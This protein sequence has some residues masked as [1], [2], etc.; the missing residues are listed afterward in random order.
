MKISTKVSTNAAREAGL[1]GRGI[2]RYVLAGLL[3]WAALA[4][5]GTFWYVRATPPKAEKES[6][7]SNQNS[8]VSWRENKSKPIVRPP[9][10]KAADAKMRPDEF[11]IGVEVN[12][13]AR[14]YCLSSFDHPM[15]HLVNDMIGD[16]AV[17]IAYCNLTRC[18]KVY[19]DAS[20]KAPLDAEIAGLLDRE[21]VIKLRGVPFFQGSGEPV[22]PAETRAEIPYDE[23]TPTL[24]NWQQWSHQHP[25]SDVYVGNRSVVRKE[26]MMR[27]FP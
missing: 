5:A 4:A 15:G 6:I 2:N 25:E 14:A 3:A 13:R 19:T 10:L 16:T 20:A 8:A 18:V 22:A 24:A 9:I 7:A 11:V 23:L 17:S 26:N 12:G 1:P 27:T 21:M